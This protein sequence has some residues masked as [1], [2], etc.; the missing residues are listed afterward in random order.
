MKNLQF[1]LFGILFLL[2]STYA[3]KLWPLNDE[4]TDEILHSSG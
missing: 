1:E 3:T 4:L 2:A